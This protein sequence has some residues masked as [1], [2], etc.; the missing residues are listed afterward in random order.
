MK[1]FFL[2]IFTFIFIFSCNNSSDLKEF[3]Q[4]IEIP[5]ILKEVGFGMTEDTIKQGIRLG[6]KTF[7][8]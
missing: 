3:V 7:D 8:I 4:N 6:I 5:I 1:K 2:L